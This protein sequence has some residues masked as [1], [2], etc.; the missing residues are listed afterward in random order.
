MQEPC[1]LQAEYN[2]ST[3][4]SA[5][6]LQAQLLLN[7]YFLPYIPTSGLTASSQA[8]SGGS[9][10]NCQPVRQDILVIEQYTGSVHNETQATKRNIMLE[11]LI[12][13]GDVVAQKSSVV[14]HCTS[15]PYKQANVAHCT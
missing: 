2:R 11:W 5:F 12:G 10:S 3:N 7:H 14:F 4:Q 9:K 6:P 15:G 1:S 13:R 8:G